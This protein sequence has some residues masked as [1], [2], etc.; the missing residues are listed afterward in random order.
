MDPKTYRFTI[1]AIIAGAAA[2][3][4]AFLAV[5]ETAAAVNVAGGAGSLLA[6]MAVGALLK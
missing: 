5:G 2:A 4:V 3:I 6:V 1:G